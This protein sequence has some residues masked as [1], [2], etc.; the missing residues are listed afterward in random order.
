MRSMPVW[1]SD[2]VKLS[3]GTIVEKVFENLGRSFFTRRNLEFSAIFH[4]SVNANRIADG[5]RLNNQTQAVGQYRN[6]RIDCG[7]RYCRGLKSSFSP[8][9]ATAPLWFVAAQRIR[10][11][12]VSL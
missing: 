10:P 4:P 9:P 3:L 8:R 5:L 2:A 1:K 6:L 12:N 11:P 7:R